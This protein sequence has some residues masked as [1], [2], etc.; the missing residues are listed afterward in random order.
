MRLKVYSDSKFVIC[1]CYEDT[2]RPQHDITERYDIEWKVRETVWG[3]RY[4]VDRKSWLV[5]MI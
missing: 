5:F 4:S 3:Y 1:T 2:L